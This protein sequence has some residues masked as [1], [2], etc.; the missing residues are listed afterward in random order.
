MKNILVAGAA[1]LAFVATAAH[2][3]PKTDGILM[4]Q[5]YDLMRL[6]GKACAEEGRVPAFASS[7]GPGK[8]FVPICVELET[9]SCFNYGAVLINSGVPKETAWEEQRKCIQGFGWSYER[10]KG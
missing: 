8:P 10:P 7:P 1:A 3:A 6:F 5:G 2:A 4:T 9:V